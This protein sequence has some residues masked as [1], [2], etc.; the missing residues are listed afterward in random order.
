MSSTTSV[1]VD[2]YKIAIGS[3]L[4]AGA[5]RMILRNES[6]QENITFG[7]SVGIAFAVAPY[8]NS[9]L[10]NLIP[11]S[12]LPTGYNGLTIEQRV[13]EILI[14]SATGYALNRFGF[15]NDFNPSDMLMKLGIIVGVDVLATYG[16]EAM[17]GAS[18]YS[19]LS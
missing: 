17:N 2:Y 19:F 6:T 8:V 1:T 9:Y 10:P 16:S 14:G 5:D 18:T 3:L 11:S 7:A 4:A 13:S 12:S 15:Y